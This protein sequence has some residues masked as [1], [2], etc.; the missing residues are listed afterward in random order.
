M[1]AR[2]VAP[3]LSIILAVSAVESSA[4]AWEMKSVVVND[5]PMCTASL[6]LGASDILRPVGHPRSFSLMVVP[7]TLTERRERGEEE[8][9]PVMYLRGF[10][11]HHT[12]SRVSPTGFQLFNCWLRGYDVGEVVEHCELDDSEH[13]ITYR[14]GREDTE[15]AWVSV[16][17]NPG[18]AIL[19]GEG[20]S[21][22]PA[23]FTRA[24]QYS[25]WLDHPDEMFAT[26][27]PRTI[28][29][30]AGGNTRPDPNGLVS[31]SVLR[32][33]L[34]DA[35]WAMAWMQRCAQRHLDTGRLASSGVGESLLGPD[36]D[37]P[38]VPGMF[39]ETSEPID[40]W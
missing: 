9:K 31:P 34:R 8:T 18:K 21:N 26:N 7:W 28:S 37:F 5:Y 23:T 13:R 12:R 15:E 33:E 22:V 11:P 16:G 4:A 20:R 19:Y 1:K 6:N 14:I 32:F 17:T 35:K 30:N 29:I 40:D 36:G 27:E 24:T 3:I 10:G 39:D 25:I 38:F 2:I